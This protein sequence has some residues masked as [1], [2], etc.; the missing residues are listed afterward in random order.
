[1]KFRNS[2]IPHQTTKLDIG[3]FHKFQI[4]E[5]CK[6][7]IAETYKLHFPCHVKLDNFDDLNNGQMGKMGSDCFGKIAGWL[8]NSLTFP[9]QFAKM[10]SNYGRRRWDLLRILTVKILA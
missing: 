10:W 6:F 9:K 2:I 1:M 8:C 4:Y 5:T 7:H 3:K